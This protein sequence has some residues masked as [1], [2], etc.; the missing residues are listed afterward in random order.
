MTFTAEQKLKAIQREL[1]LRRRCYPQWITKGLMKPND[2]RHQI[3]IFEAIE[4]DYTA[5]SEAR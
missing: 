3:A 2:A 1:A 5:K 4:A